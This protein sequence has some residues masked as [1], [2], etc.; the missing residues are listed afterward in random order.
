MSTAM[1]PKVK[2]IPKLVK[3]DRGLKLAESWVNNM[4]GSAMDESTETE[5][6]QSARPARLGLGAKATHRSKQ[7]SWADPVERKLLIKLEAKKRAAAKSKEESNPSESE[8]DD[9]ND[10][11]P[12]CRSSAFNK[13]RTLPS[14]AP[15][16][17]NKKHK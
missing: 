13:K 6:E 1:P 9:S 14:V 5:V 2:V 12:E 7:E 8:V 3:L 4:S 17:K 15:S 11:D 10:D 16:L